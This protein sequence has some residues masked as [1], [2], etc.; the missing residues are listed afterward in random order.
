MLNKL[1]VSIALAG[2]AIASAAQHRVTFFEESIVNGIRLKPG[3][4]KLVIEGDKAKLTGGK[5]TVEAQVS[6]QKADAKY[7]TTSVRY[8]ANGGTQAVQE[9]RLGGTATKVIFESNTPAAAA[10]GR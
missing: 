9:I 6:V 8:G 2:M 5:Q 10:G 1:V 4:Y 3:D 7:G